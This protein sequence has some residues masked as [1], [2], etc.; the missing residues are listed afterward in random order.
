M[1]F[2]KVVFQLLGRLSRED[3]IVLGILIFFCIENRC[4]KYLKIVLV[5]I[6]LS[7]LEQGLFGK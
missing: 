1:G 4:D 7:G 6:F 5:I 3:L 2:E